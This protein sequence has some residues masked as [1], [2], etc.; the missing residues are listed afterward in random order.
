MSASARGKV[1]LNGKSSNFL[2][3]TNGNGNGNGNS[4][5]NGSGNHTALS[6][7]YEGHDR[8]EVTRILIQALGDLGYSG[9]A[10]AL[11]RESGY[12]LESP[13][14]VAFRKAVLGGQWAEA[15]HLLLASFEDSPTT[16]LVKGNEDNEESAPA[17][18]KLALAENADKRQMLFL[19]RRHKFLE[20]LQAR[21]LGAALM[22]LRQE[23]TP[24][25]HNI[26]E[27]HALSRYACSE[28]ILF[29]TA[30]TI[31]QP[32]SVDEPGRAPSRIFKL[33]FTQ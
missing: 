12:Q 3:H 6:T 9:A 10:S 27:L 28:D 30:L 31:S 25:N 13:S 8:Q 7:S 4:N 16:S 19:L 21:D 23:L 24:L 32:Q 20:L 11:A 29:C 33:A 18:C 1:A 5:S 17:W 14:V 26:A 2:N 22:V 15:E